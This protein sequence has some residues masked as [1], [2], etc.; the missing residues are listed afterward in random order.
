MKKENRLATFWKCYDSNSKRQRHQFRFCIHRSPL[1]GSFS[2]LSTKLSAAKP[3]QEG[4]DV[5]VAFLS[6][7]SS[8]SWVVHVLVKCHCQY[9][10]SIIKILVLQPYYFYIVVNF[11]QH[12][13]ICTYDTTYSTPIHTDIYKTAYIEISHHR[14]SAKTWKTLETFFP[15]KA[16]ENLQKKILPPNGPFVPQRAT[17]RGV[18]GPHVHVLLSQTEPLSSRASWW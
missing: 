13:T 14:P 2:R 4:R 18:L 10:T 15:S 17:C 3:N 16:P 11:M 7:T 8:S 1:E 6:V 9:S 12:S 5:Q